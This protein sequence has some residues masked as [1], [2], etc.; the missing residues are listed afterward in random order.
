LKGDYIRGFKEALEWILHAA[1]GAK[2]LEDLV[3]KVNARYQVVLERHILNLED[4]FHV[5]GLT[6]PLEPEQKS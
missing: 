5:M 6:Q 4:E 1:N 3:Q 2:T